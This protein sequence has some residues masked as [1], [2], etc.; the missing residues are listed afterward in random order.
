MI[1]NDNQLIS[2]EI[3]LWDISVVHVSLLCQWYLKKSVGSA[4]VSHAAALKMLWSHITGKTRKMAKAQW[5]WSRKELWL[6]RSNKEKGSISNKMDTIMGWP[7]VLVVAFNSCCALAEDYPEPRSFWLNVSHDSFISKYSHFSGTVKKDICHRRIVM[8][9]ETGVGRWTFHFQLK[10]L[11]IARRKLGRKKSKYRTQ[12]KTEY[13]SKHFQKAS[14]AWRT[15][16][17]V[18]LTTPR[19]EDSLTAASR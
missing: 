6:S 4:G 2:H 7:V 15:C 3:S 5:L 9:G 10:L 14:P 13:I 16:W 1:I 17:W 11:I 18:D 12:R 19:G 8:L